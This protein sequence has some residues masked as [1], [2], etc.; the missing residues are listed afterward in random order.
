MAAPTLKVTKRNKGGRPSKL[1]TDIQTKILLAVRKG[2]YQSTA[3]KWAGVSVRSFHGWIEKGRNEPN[4]KYGQ[5]L[6]A[7]QEAEAEAEIVALQHLRRLSE[8]DWHGW[9]WFLSRKN[10]AAWGRKD[11][12]EVTKKGKVTLID[13]TPEEAVRELEACARAAERARRS[14]LVVVDRGQPLLVAASGTA[15]P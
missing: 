12:L 15:K 7:L 5:F 1:T 6:Q 11:K 10:P 3:A 14:G 4:S 2:N 13:M 9:A 8:K